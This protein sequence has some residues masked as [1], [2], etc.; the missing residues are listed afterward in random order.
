MAQAIAEQLNEELELGHDI[1]SRGIATDE[2]AGAAFS[3]IA[4]A[5][6][7]GM[8]LSK[9]IARQLIDSDVER[10]DALYTM[11]AQQR[12]ILTAWYPGAADKIQPIAPEDIE[13]PF[14]QDDDVYL[15]TFSAL[16]KAIGH[17]VGFLP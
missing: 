15:K 7:H 6:K 1:Q 10:A 3:A 17:Q 5:K 11:T 16:S 4:V 8:D 9:H 2:E 14:M 13:D 12:E